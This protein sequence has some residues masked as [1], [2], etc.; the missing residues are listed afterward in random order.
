M[1][2]FPLHVLGSVYIAAQSPK[3]RGKTELDLLLESSTQRGIRGHKLMEIIGNDACYSSSSRVFQW[4]FSNVLI[5]CRGSD[6]NQSFRYGK[7]CGY[8]VQA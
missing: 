5:L 1:S 4:S 3:L 8:F 7:L 2:S 6:G